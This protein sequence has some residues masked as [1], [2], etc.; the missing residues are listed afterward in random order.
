MTRLLVVLVLVVAVP[1]CTP[2]TTKR[3]ATPAE[4]GAELAACSVSS[5]T[6][7][8]SIACENELRAKHKRP[9]RDPAK[10]CD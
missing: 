3:A 1:A 7:D 2:S 6:C 10:G 9:L 8:Q 4:Y 5:T